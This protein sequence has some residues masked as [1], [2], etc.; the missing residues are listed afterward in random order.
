MSSVLIDASL[1][2]LLA[3]TCLIRK[4]E[5]AQDQRIRGVGT[6]QRQLQRHQPV[7][8]WPGVALLVLA[9]PG[10]IG[11][12]YPCLSSQ[13]NTCSSSILLFPHAYGA[14]PMQGLYL[15]V[16]DRGHHYG[17]DFIFHSQTRVCSTANIT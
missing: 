13:P 10:K 17:L 6:V 16:K 4:E 14:I 15:V 3:H 2:R 12:G 1:T 11:A 7:T 9:W 5:T 8:E